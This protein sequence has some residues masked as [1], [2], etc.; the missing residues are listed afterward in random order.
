MS[1]FLE[2][3]FEATQRRQFTQFR[4][5]GNNPLAIRLMRLS[6]RHLVIGSIVQSSLTILPLLVI[7]LLVGQNHVTL[8]AVVFSL[9]FLTIFAWLFL[10][11]RWR[12]SQSAE[13][14][15]AASSGEEPL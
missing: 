7:V 4:G 14:S 12:R 9:S 15:V 1:G 5:M 10:Y 8:V 6:V 2:R 13:Q 3:R 11:N